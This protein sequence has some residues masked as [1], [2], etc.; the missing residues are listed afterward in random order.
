MSVAQNKSD[1]R[2]IDRRSK[3]RPKPISSDLDDVDLSREVAGHF[4]TNFLLA[5]FRFRPRLHGFLQ[6][7]LSTLHNGSLGIATK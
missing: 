1:G 7:W 3:V 2:N 5:N 6:V 4:E